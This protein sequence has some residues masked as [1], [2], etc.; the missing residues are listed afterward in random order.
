MDLKTGL[1]FS[2]HTYGGMTD[3]SDCK[4]EFLEG[5][6]LFRR[7]FQSTN[8]HT[9]YLY[10]SAAEYINIDWYTFDQK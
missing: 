4:D 8:S 3:H 10:P 1:Y 6:R 9:S 2:Y 7:R 5:R